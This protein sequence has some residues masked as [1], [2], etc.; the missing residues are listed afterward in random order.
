MDAQ[1]SDIIVLETGSCKICDL[2]YI[3]IATQCH[4]S[5]FCINIDKYKSEAF[6]LHFNQSDCVCLCVVVLCAY[7]HVTYMSA[8]SC[9]TQSEQTMLYLPSSPYNLSNLLSSC[10]YPRSFPDARTGTLFMPLPIIS[11]LACTGPRTFQLG[12][13]LLT[14]PILFYCF[15]AHLYLHF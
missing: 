10:D 1:F 6:Y 4:F 15:S 9:F 14:Q 7:L 11:Y 3:T 13:L 2:C 5:G 12:L 8:G